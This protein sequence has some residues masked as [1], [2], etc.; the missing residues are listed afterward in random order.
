MHKKRPRNAGVCSCA[1]QA[2]ILLALFALT[3]LTATHYNAAGAA[4]AVQRIFQDLFEKVSKMP[5]LDTVFPPENV[6]LRAARGTG[7][8]CFPSVFWQC[9]LLLFCCLFAAFPSFALEKWTNSIGMEFVKIPTGT[10]LRG[11]NSDREDCKSN[12]TP[13][14]RISI[15]S[16]WMGTYKVT[17]AQWEAVMG[18]NPSHFQEGN[19]RNHPVETVS[20]HDAQEFV[21]RLNAKEGHNRYRL[22]TEAE[23]EYAARA[24]SKTAYSFGDNERDLGDYAWYVKNS[25]FKTHPVGQK[26]PNAWGLHDIHGN[27]MEWVQD[28]YDSEYYASSET[29][30]PRGPSEGWTRVL[31]GCVWGHSNT[32]CRSAYRHSRAPDSRSIVS[33]AGFG[34]RLA[35]TPEH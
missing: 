19:T 27:V 31:R 33:G 25:D 4:A 16:F 32:Y 34:F 2:S 22:P 21:R 12:E 11:C 26:R 3:T 23:W 6:K 20:W 9:F 29:D 18:G 10:Y 7:A 1:H 8:A 17:Q 30:N 15:S 28:W 14:R 24:G 35:L 5:A 13:Q